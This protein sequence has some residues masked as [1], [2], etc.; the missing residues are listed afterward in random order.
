MVTKSGAQ[1]KWLSMHASTLLPLPIIHFPLWTLAPSAVHRSGVWP[2]EV[3]SQW[4]GDWRRVRQ[5]TYPSRSLNTRS[6]QNL[7]WPKDT[8]S[9]RRLS[10]KI[11]YTIKLR[12]KIEFYLSQSDDYNL[13]SR[14]S[15][16]LRTVLPIRSWRHSHIHFHDKD[17]HQN[18]TLIL[19]IRFTKDTQSRWA[20]IKPAAGYYDP[21]KQEKDTILLR[22]HIA[23][24]R[25][26]RNGSLWS[27]RHS[28][29]WGALVSVIQRQGADWGGRKEAQTQRDFTFNFFLVLP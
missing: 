11:Q 12:W 29:V 22:S 23:S 18:D 13:G 21:A 15:E 26:K 19:D 2:T 17:V 9:I 20:C 24:F 16:V 5:T 8:T 6:K 28:C 14:F 1:L 4:W 25:R 3:T 7:P 10:T 27:S